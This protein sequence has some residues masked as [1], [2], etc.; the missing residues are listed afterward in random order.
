M[1][2]TKYE[3]MLD[4]LMATICTQV[5]LHGENSE[6]VLFPS[7][8]ATVADAGLQIPL[9]SPDLVYGRLLVS[10]VLILYTCICRLPHSPL[11]HHHPL[12]P[13]RH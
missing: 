4:D 1:V 9:T 8:I 10:L 7:T 12:R 6:H 3:D 13:R 5:H 2:W 11:M